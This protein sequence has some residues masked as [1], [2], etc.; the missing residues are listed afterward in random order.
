[1]DAPHRC[2]PS[3]PPLQLKS[4]IYYFYLCIGNKIQWFGSENLN[5]KNVFRTTFSTLQ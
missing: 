3:L 5:N 4:E 2:F 1:M